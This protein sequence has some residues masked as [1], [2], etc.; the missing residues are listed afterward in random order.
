[1]IISGLY[2]IINT[3][4]ADT[5]ALC[6][7]RAE[8]ALKGGCKTLQL[9]SKIWPAQ[10]TLLLAQQLQKLCAKY[11]CCFLINDDPQLALACNANGV[12]IG[13][14]DSKLAHCREALGPQAIIGVSCH[15]SLSL[16]QSAIEGSADYIA[17]GRFFNSKTKPE[18]PPAELSI[19]TQ[20]KEQFNCPV[21]AI[22]GINLDNA[23]HVISAGAD[24]IA[25][26]DAL[27]NAPNIELAAQL[28]SRNFIQNE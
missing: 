7:A 18:A 27:F 1:M 8:A 14:Q 16:A 23:P 10:E 9:R 22:G 20:A 21:V 17:F 26:I 2:G 6:L 15:N 28:F 13:Q 3:Q 12:H 25:V 24:S 5:P 19:L 4:A 11:Q